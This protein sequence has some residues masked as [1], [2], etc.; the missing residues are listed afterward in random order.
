MFHT[1]SVDRDTVHTTAKILLGAVAL[2][3][4]AYLLTLLPGVDRVIPQ[5]PITVAALISAVVTLVVVALLLSAGPK[6]ASLTRMSLDGPRELVENI[7][8]LVYWL[9]VLAAVL[10]AHAGL[11]GAV[12]PVFGDLVWLYD[13]LFLLA[14]LPA[15]AAIAARLYAGLDPA[16]AVLTDRVTDPDE[17]DA[18]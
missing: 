12:V 6:L 10:V 7:A 17:Q 15:I 3:A 8:S 18:N 5:T 1:S 4:F 11:S 9:V 16:A 2:L 13:V 14:A